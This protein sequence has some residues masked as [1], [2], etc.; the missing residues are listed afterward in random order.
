MKKMV[1]DI[2]GMSCAHCVRHVTEA[3]QALSEV[4]AVSVDLEAGQAKLEAA[5]T[6]APEAIRAAVDEAG[7]EVTGV[8]AN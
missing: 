3:L 7:Y 4:S 8:R 5:D 2:D 6:L 1:I